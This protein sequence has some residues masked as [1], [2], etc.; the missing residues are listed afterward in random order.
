MNNKTF[1]AIEYPLEAYANKAVVNCTFTIQY[2]DLTPYDFS[3]ASGYYLSIFD[4]RGGTLLKRWFDGAGLDI[5]DNVI[6][7]NERNEAIMNLSL[8]KYYYELGYTVVDY[9]TEDDI[10]LSFGQIKFI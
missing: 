9:S 5:A 7:W 2:S 4:R 10:P 8:G 3:D 6:T 1:R